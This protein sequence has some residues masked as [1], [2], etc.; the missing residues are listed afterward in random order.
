MAKNLLVV[1]S[2][3]KAKTI[4]RYLG[5]D[6]QVAPSVGHVMDLP[7]STLGVDVEHDFK[8]EY[9]VIPGKAKV[10]EDIKKAAKGKDKIFLRPTPT[11]RARRLPGTSP[12]SSIRSAAIFAAFSCMKLLRRR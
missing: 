7:K 11:A 12:K 9:V 2:P 8:P 4:K 10:I 1:E 6:F 5:S 3:A